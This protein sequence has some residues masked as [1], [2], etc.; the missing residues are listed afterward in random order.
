MTSTIMRVSV[1]PLFL[2]LFTSVTMINI[3]FCIANSNVACI[4]SER[5]ALLKLKQ[6]LNDPSN[7]LASWNIGDGDCCAWD[8]VVCNNF[9]GHVL[10]LNLGNP[11]PNHGTGSKLVGKINPSLV[12]IKHLIHL[13]LSGNDF[14]GI[15]IPKYL[16]SLQNLRYLNL[17]G[18]EFAGVIPHQLGNLSN[19]HYL[20]LSK[21]FYELQVES[22]L[23]LSGL[24]LLEHLD[25]S[26]VDLSKSSDYLLTINSLPSLRVLKL[27][28]CELHHFPSLSS[29]NFSSLKALDLSGNHFNN[30]LFQYSSWVFGLRNLVFFDL[31]NNEFQGKIPIGL[32]NLTFLRRLDLSSNEFNSAI[33]GWLSK[34]NDLEFLSLRGNSLQGKISSMGLEKLTS[35]KTLDL[36]L[37]YEL[38]GKIPTS[39]VRLCKLT[40]ID[41]SYVKLS[42]DL[43]QVLDIFSACDAY[44][45]ESL[46]LRSCQCSGHLTNQLGQFKSLNRLRL[47]NNSLSGPLPSALGELTY[48]TDLDLSR[49]RLNGSIPLSLGQNLNLEYLDLSNNLLNGSIPLSLGKF[50]HLEYLDLSNNRMSGTLSENHFVNLTKLTSFST[51]GNSLI[52][53]VNPN[54]VPPFQLDELLLRSCHLGP[55]FPSWLHSQKHLSDLDISNT[56]ISDTIPRWF[57][58][59]IS[60]Y[61][62]LNLSS[63]Q[64][65]GEIPNLDFD[66]R[67]SP[68]LPPSSGILDFSNNGFS[69]SIFH[70]ICNGLKSISYLQ[71]SKNYFSGDI[72]DCWMNWPGLGMLNLGNNNLTGSLPASIGT[73]S[74]LWSLNL[75]NNRLSGVIPASFQNCSGLVYL[76]MDENEFVGNIPTWMGERFSGLSILILRSNKFHGYLPIQLCRLTSLQILDVA[77]NNL[78]GTIPR[79]ISNFTAMATTDSSNLQNAI[80]Y[81]TMMDG[82]EAALDASV[83]TKGFMVEYDSILNLVR[84]IDIS[85][86]NFSGEI[87]MELTNLKGLQSLNLSHNFF[88]SKIPEKI[89]NMKSIESLDFSANQLSGEIPQS[90]SSLS[91]LNHLN[92]SNNHL[93]GKIPSSTQLQSFDSSCFAGNNLCG[94]PLPNCT[95]NN[96]LVPEDPNGNGNEDEDEVDW[97]LYLSLALGFVVGFW[98][99][100]GSLLVSRRWRYKYCHFLDGI[101]DEFGCFV[102][103]CY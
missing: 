17:S 43:S 27:S 47:G 24:S 72:P 66:N 40:S 60:Q 68:L 5:Q 41:L 73:L 4:D 83:V 9:T 14:Q 69:G 8:G 11:D 33:P 84:S 44:A 46:V 12:D 15:H 26:Q 1:A 87:P 99:F 35:I 86:N 96:P 7:R 23:W 97:L 90:M 39:F 31:G 91:F 56:R 21:N 59:S 25:L 93:T 79:C 52:L 54:W 64:I 37:N 38:S 89:G 75:R 42:Q 48:L 102:R 13:D 101:M 98:G 78:S 19:L 51:S 3:S 32:G 70:L 55:H 22:F 2:E 18:A 71:L 100:I 10:Q 29:A 103:R 36:S 6:D 58:N 45:L 63:N 82:T 49:N 77:N 81:V 34:L 50:S 53:Q 85:K 16:G 80:S 76:D 92:L 20:D 62:F 65:Y 95:G 30:S 57:W 28:Y 67:P 61:K 94:A 74:F 88:T